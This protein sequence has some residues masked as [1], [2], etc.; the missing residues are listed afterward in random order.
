MKVYP[1]VDFYILNPEITG[2]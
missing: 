2:K 1:N